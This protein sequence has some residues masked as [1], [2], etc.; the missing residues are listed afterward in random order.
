MIKFQSFSKRINARRSC[1]FSYSKYEFSKFR[2]HRKYAQFI[3]ENVLI[4][5]AFTCS[6]LPKETLEY[7]R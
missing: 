2:G 3:F 1:L 7:K 6:K 4:Q 5:Q